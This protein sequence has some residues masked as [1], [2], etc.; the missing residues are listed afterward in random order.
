MHCSCLGVAS[1]FW[2]NLNLSRKALPR[3][4]EKT[5]I[6]LDF[7]YPVHRVTHIEAQVRKQK[8]SD[9]RQF[10]LSQLATGEVE[11]QE[12]R[13]LARAAGHSDYAI[14]TALKELRTAG[15][16]E[17]AKAGGQGNRKILKLTSTA[18]TSQRVVV[19]NI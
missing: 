1:H 3:Y 8:V 7:V 5:D 13:R 17:D 18:S 6:G 16:I 2:W 12:L 4:T 9:A 10:F 14:W 19:S 11:E 15:E